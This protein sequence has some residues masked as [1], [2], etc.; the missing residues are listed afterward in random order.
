MAYAD[1]GSSGPISERLEAL[2]SSH[3]SLLDK[4]EDLDRRYQSLDERMQRMPTDI[5]SDFV[6]LL[7]APSERKQTKKSP[8]Q[9]RFSFAILS[10]SPKIGH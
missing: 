7:S 6:A 2:L 9:A 1:E 3:E 5:L 4:Y 10:Y 8:L